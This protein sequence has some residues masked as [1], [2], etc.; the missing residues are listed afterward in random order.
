VFPVARQS[1]LWKGPM[2][3]VYMASRD[4]NHMA[5][6]FDHLPN[7]LGSGSGPCPGGSLIELAI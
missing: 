2:R 1:V 4:E 3:Q 7:L 6:C 5:L